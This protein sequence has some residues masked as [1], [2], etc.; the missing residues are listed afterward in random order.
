MPTCPFRAERINQT[1]APYRRRT[2]QTKYLRGHKVACSPEG[3]PRK[4]S[5]RSTT[6]PLQGLAGLVCQSQGF[7]GRVEYGSNP[8]QAYSSSEKT[9]EATPLHPVPRTAETSHE[10]GR[11]EFLFVIGISLRERKN[12]SSFRYAFTSLH[13]KIWEAW[14]SGNAGV[15]GGLAGDPRAYLLIYPFRGSEYHRV[16]TRTRT[17]FFLRNTRADL[18]L[19]DTD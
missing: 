1:L 15:P 16:Y 5:Q 10:I 14:N 4:I 12:T 13:D 3:Q 18:F 7:A 6:A 19:H 2:P 9:Y 8:N 17:D 11:P